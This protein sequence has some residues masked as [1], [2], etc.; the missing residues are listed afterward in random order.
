[1]GVYSGQ[2]SRM[3]FPTYCEARPLIYDRWLGHSVS[4]EPCKN[5]AEGQAITFTYDVSGK[6]ASLLVRYLCFEHGLASVFFC[7]FPDMIES[8]ATCL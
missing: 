7:P 3:T 5:K 4:G 8:E 1:M 2:V 6:L